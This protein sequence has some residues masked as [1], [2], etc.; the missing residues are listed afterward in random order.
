MPATASTTRSWSNASRLVLLVRLVQLV[1]PEHGF[2][3][4]PGL[5][6]ASCCRRHG[7]QQ[8]AV[9]RTSGFNCVLSRRAALGGLVKPKQVPPLKKMPTKVV[10]RHRPAVISGNPHAVTE[11]HRHGVDAASVTVRGGTDRGT[12]SK[13]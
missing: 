5:R 2:A 4:K 9:L 3:R 10:R 12:R 11:S 13:E 7:L 6:T 1:L 8:Q